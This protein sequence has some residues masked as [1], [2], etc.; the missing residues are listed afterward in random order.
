MEIKSALKR[1]K[2]VTV[3]SVILTVLAGG[4]MFFGFWQGALYVLAAGIL[5]VITSIL[6]LM[7]SYIKDKEKD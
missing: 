6:D 3:M 4:V 1:T 2:H 5:M 7:Y